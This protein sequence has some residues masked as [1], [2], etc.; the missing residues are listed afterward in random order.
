MDSGHF[1][2]CRILWCA[3]LKLALQFRCY[4]VL[5]LLV[6][7][8]RHAVVKRNKKFTLIFCFRSDLVITGDVQRGAVNRT[9]T[10]WRNVLSVAS[11][12]GIND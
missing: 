2:N 11:R 10:R 6:E 8:E 1:D 12:R 5:I 4:F 7:C 3:L 9:I